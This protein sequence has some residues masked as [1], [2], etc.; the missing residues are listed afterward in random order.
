MQPNFINMF[1]RLQGH[2][3]DVE[4]VL[5]GGGTDRVGDQ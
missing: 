1:W 2:L 5:E 4:G 3:K